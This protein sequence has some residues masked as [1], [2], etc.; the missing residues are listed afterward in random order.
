LLR[1]IIGGELMMVEGNADKAM[2]SA[3]DMQ[4]GIDAWHINHE[5]GMRGIGSRIQWV[6][7]SYDTFTYRL[8]RASGAMTENEKR[9][10][11]I[12][13]GGGWVYPHLTVHAYIE[14]P[15]RMGAL[16]SFA[17]AKTTDIIDYIERF[18]DSI[19]IQ[20]VINDGGRKY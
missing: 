10:R 8:E 9:R 14:N 2:Q 5:Y 3:L 6:Y 7:K 4:A 12:I 11:A 15:R 19:Q 18:K 13:E 16:I 20:T 1:L 17:V